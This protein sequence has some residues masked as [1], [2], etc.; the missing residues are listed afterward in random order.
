[1]HPH[2]RTAFIFQLDRTL[3]G[4]GCYWA[5]QKFQELTSALAWLRF[6]GGRRLQMLLERVVLQT[7]CAGGLVEPV[8]VGEGRRFLP[9][10]LGQSGTFVGLSAAPPIELAT[11]PG[12]GH[13]N[14]RRLS[15][16]HQSVSEKSVSPARPTTRPMGRRSSGTHRPQLTIPD[17]KNYFMQACRK[18]TTLQVI[19]GYVLLGALVTRFAVLFT[20]GGP[21]GRF[22]DEKKEKDKRQQETG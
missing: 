22:A 18:D 4:W 20:A 7:Q 8:F 6:V 5:W 9:E 3:D 21:A 17:K 16:A 1:V 2:R 13:G 12:Q 10:V 11:R 19:W 15:G 14:V